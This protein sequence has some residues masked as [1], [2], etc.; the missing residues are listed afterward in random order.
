V[1]VRASSGAASAGALMQNVLECAMLNR[2]VDFASLAL[3]N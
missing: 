1:G 2:T 3:R